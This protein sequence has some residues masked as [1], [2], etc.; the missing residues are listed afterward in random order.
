MRLLRDP[1]RQPAVVLLEKLYQAAYGVTKWQAD[2]GADKLGSQDHANTMMQ[3]FQQGDNDDDIWE[4]V[5]LE[6]FAVQSIFTDMKSRREFLQDCRVEVY[7]QQLKNQNTPEVVEDQLYRVN[8]TITRVARL[9]GQYLA[10][11]RLVVPN[12]TKEQHS[13]EKISLPTCKITK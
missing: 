10:Q 2:E 4:L 6:V 8:R 7:A 13:E 12:C 3:I 5:G 11:A 1:S 9:F